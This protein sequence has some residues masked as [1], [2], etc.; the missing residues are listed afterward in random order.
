MPKLIPAVISQHYISQTPDDQ[1][2]ATT[3]YGWRFHGGTLLYTY[4][5][6]SFHPS[7]RTWGG[8]GAP[9]DHPWEEEHQDPSAVPGLLDDQAKMT[10]P[11]LDEGVRQ[12]V[13]HWWTWR[14]PWAPTTLESPSDLWCLEQQEVNLGVATSDVGVQSCQG[15][16]PV[17][18]LVRT[19]P[20]EVIQSAPDW[21]Q[22]SAEDRRFDRHHQNLTFVRL[23]FFSFYLN[24]TFVH[25][26]PSQ[27]V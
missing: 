23:Y 18:L 4:F 12:L 13:D 11:Q 17:Q 22:M 7:T 20:G 19:R 14:L 27:M 26:V 24:F 8:G 9:G 3:S 25:L 6:T 1:D 15:W 5:S 10:T 2:E 16:S 21:V